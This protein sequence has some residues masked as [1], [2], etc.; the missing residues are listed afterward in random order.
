MV[1]EDVNDKNQGA[2]LVVPVRQRQVDAQG[3][4]PFRAFKNG[5]DK[6]QADVSREYAH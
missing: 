6:R 5:R 1:L 3:Y 4:L 2:Y